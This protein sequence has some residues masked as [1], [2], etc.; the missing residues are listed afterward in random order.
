MEKLNK[1]IDDIIIKHLLGESSAEEQTLLL[2]WLKDDIQNQDYFFQ[3]KEIWTASQKQVQSETETSWNNLKDSIEKGKEVALTKTSKPYLKVLRYAA[4]FAALF[5]MAFLAYRY[6]PKVFNREKEITFTEVSTTNGQKKEIQLPDGTIIWV[7]SGTTLKYASNFGETDR[8]VFL[9]GEAYFD[10]KHD[11]SKTFIVRAQ[12]VTIKVL[13][14]SFNVRCYP[15][16]KTIETTVVSGTVSMESTNK[17]DEK[18]IVILGKKEKATFLKNEQKM[19]I[20]RT[21]KDSKTSV[22]PIGLKKITLNDEETNY[23]SSWKDQTLSF[24]NES[25]EEMAFKLE[26][27]FN[28]TIIIRDDKLKSYR[29]KGKFENNKSIF[30]VLKV[31]KLTT[32]ITYDYNEKTKEITIKEIK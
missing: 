27:W 3:M 15:E 14:T 16:L 10:V 20:T 30:E 9:Q 7:N 5:S 31:V 29:Y 11:T 28:V 1:N 22:E 17:T 19:Y 12:N 26:K 6:A 21:L 4:I 25:F 13:G 2:S 23:I 24:N 8:E 32:P 18:D